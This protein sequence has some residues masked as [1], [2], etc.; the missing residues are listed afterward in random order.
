MQKS[1]AKVYGLKES[2]YRNVCPISC[3][4]SLFF[5]LTIEMAAAFLMNPINT[6]KQAKRE[7]E[8]EGGF[9]CCCL[10]SKH[11]PWKISFEFT[12]GLPVQEQLN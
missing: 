9:A 1:S 12:R 2:V 10:Y 5:S 4:F 7:K 8:K 6:C 3:F 11:V